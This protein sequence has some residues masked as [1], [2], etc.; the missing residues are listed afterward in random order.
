MQKENWFGHTNT[1]KRIDPET[2]AIQDRGWFGWKDTGERIDPETGNHQK[3]GL[4]GYYSGGRSPANSDGSD[5]TEVKSESNHSQSTRGSSTS[6]GSYSSRSTRH[7]RFPVV[8][9]FWLFLF[10]ALH[11]A[12]QERGS[13][14]RPSDSIIRQLFWT[15]ASNSARVRRVFYYR[16]PRKIR[17]A[18][19]LRR[20]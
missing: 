8:L 12:L 11:I 9:V 5:T 6:G 14:N 4:F 17:S 20:Q 7:G 2:G 18:L 1:D 15:R 16:A 3:Q 13:S 10:A 19:A